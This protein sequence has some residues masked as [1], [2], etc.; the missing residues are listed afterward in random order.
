MTHIKYMTLPNIV[1]LPPKISSFFHPFAGPI[2]I[3]I[4]APDLKLGHNVAGTIYY[5]LKRTNMAW[6]T[7]GHHLPHRFPLFISHNYRTSED[8]YMN[9]IYKILKWLD[10]TDILP[11]N[12]FE[13]TASLFISIWT[14]TITLTPSAL[15]VKSPFSKTRH[16]FVI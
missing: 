2:S 11:T 13:K 8:I 14:S 4:D 1:R 7:L 6:N 9:T 15:V 16:S 12:R 3:T 5:I 10:L